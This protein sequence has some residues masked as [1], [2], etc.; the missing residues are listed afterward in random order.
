M[1]K[2]LLAAAMSALI[3]LAT[4]VSAFAEAAIYQGDDQGDSM[5]LTYNVSQNYTIKIPADIK[6]TQS[7][8]STSGTISAEDVLI[9]TGKKLSV[10]V[11]SK[12]G[13][14][15]DSS[16]YKLANGGS[17]IPYTIKSGDALIDT[18]DPVLTITAG[19]TTGSS[20]LAFA[21]STDDIAKATLSGDHSD[22]LTFSVTVANA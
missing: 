13:L 5:K 22:T 20:T 18:S 3:A 4:P 15:D 12:N 6:F 9:P 14:T 1:N 16:A 11:Q 7:T 2:K 8:L 21:T 10:Y 19:N 17:V